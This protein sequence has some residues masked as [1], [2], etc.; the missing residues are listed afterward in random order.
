MP[1]PG[2]LGAFQALQTFATPSRLYKTIIKAVPTRKARHKHRLLLGAAPTG[3]L[4][5]LR[6]QLTILLTKQFWSL[7]KSAYLGVEGSEV[8]LRFEERFC[9][10]CRANGLP[11]GRLRL[12]HSGNRTAKLV[13]SMSH[14]TDG[15]VQL[16]RQRAVLMKT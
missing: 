11:L 8:G 6:H 4:L 3:M 5:H 15:R 9:R 12:T 14:V 16:R 13:A 10:E 7:T 2:D 1:H